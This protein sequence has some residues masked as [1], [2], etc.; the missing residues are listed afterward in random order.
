MTD[1]VIQAHRLTRYFGT[2]CAADQV[3]FAI[4]R[5]CIAALLGRNGS[6]KTTIMRMLLGLLEPTRGASTV[7]GHSSL[8]IPPEIRS[9][10]GYVAE[11]H[12]LYGW[13]TVGQLAEHQS[14]FYRT[15]NRAIY[16]SIIDHFQLSDTARSGSLSRGQRAGV[17]LALAL[18]PEPE[19]L[20]LDDPSLGLDPVARRA[21]LEVIINVWS[22]GGGGERTI[23]LSTHELQ[24]VERIADRVLLLDHSVLVADADKDYFLSHVRE[25]VAEVDEDGPLQ[26]RA[27]EIRGL[28]STRREGKLLRLL[29][30]NADTDTQQ[31]IAAVTG[32]LAQERDV[33]LEDAVIAYLSRRGSALDERAMGGAA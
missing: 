15:W 16:R 9:R 17:A 25:Y 8:A 12:P 19:L 29:V 24:D 31:A 5:G 6:G 1:C 4:P 23:L 14:A 13:M 7:L 2:N 26:L 21:I 30:A 33:S 22:A 10:I 32:T 11:G 27:K 18:A 20:V 3:S 28:V